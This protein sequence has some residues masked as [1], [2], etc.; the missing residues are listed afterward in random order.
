MFNP[1][2]RPS[3]PSEGREHA[4]E[5][6]EARVAARPADPCARSLRWLL[7]ASFVGL[8]AVLVL[9]LYGQFWQPT[10]S[11]DVALTLP[12]GTEGVALA[13]VR[14]DPARGDRA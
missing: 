12:G 3:R 5:P 14:Y 11:L 10:S 2:F 1:R 8:C 7:I 6:A 13:F 4:L 9:C